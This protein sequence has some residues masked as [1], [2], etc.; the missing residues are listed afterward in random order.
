MKKA[1]DTF[2]QNGFS[3]AVIA[4]DSIYLSASAGDIYVIQ[5]RNT[6]K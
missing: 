3:G 2:E 5:Y 6:L 1:A 4:N